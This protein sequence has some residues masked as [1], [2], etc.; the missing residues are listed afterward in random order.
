MNAGYGVGQVS[1]RG[2]M[3]AAFFCGF[4]QVGAWASGPVKDVASSAGVNEELAGAHLRLGVEFF[5]TGELD[6]AIREFREAVRQRPGYAEAYHN[7]GVTLAKAGDV[8]GAIVAWEEAERLAPAVVS[9]RYRIAALVSYNFGV[10]RLH[11]KQLP[12]AMEQWREAVRLQPNLVEAHYALG[13]GYVAAGNPL[14]AVA[15]FQQALHWAPDW[16]KAH[17]GLG[18][19]YYES[20]DFG[21]AREAWLRAKELNPLEP[22]VYAN[23][24]LLAVQEGNFQEGIDYSRK[25]LDLKPTLGAAH[26]NL[27]MALFRKGEEEE[28]FKSFEAAWRL[29]SS[30][31]SAP[32]LMGIVKSHQGQWASAATLWRKALRRYPSSPERV[33]LRFNLGLALSMMGNAQ[34]AISEFRLVVQE[35]PAWAPGWAQLGQTF[36]G[37]HQWDQAVRAFQKAAESDPQS[38]YLPYAMGRALLEQGRVDE[39]GQAFWRA[40]KLEPS[41]IDAQYQLGLVLHAQHLL[42]EAAEPLRLAAEDGLHHAQGLLASMYANGSGVDRNL[43]EA[44]LWWFRHG[45]TTTDTTV[46]SSG[47]QELSRLRGALYSHRLSDADRQEVLAGFDLIRQELTRPESLPVFSGISMNGDLNWDSLQPSPAGLSWVIQMALALDGRAQDTLVRW[48]EQGEFKHMAQSDPPIQEYFL[49]TGKEGNPLSCQV[50]QRTLQSQQS[51]HL[52]MSTLVSTWE[53]VWRSCQAAS[54]VPQLT[55]KRP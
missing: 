34:D 1:V 45:Q 33:W 35:L 6:V 40:V 53:S 16:S 46:P 38:A 49:L 47:S 50:I 42:V 3:V 25:A 39:A 13:L 15:Y 41:F 36:M 27:G 20:H 10:S 30:L 12:A 54:S 8:S 21:L 23:L 28:S 2:L 51:G 29:D 4:T 31:A 11:D 17:E 37:L 52:S 22:S 26:F 14:P 5:L 19:A 7:L 44:M 24:G 55:K 32:L 9:T 48:Y 43:P 18:F